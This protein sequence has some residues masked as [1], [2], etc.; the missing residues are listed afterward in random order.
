VVAA[1]KDDDG[2]GAPSCIL[3]IINI[4]QLPK[5]SSSYYFSIK[6]VYGSVKMLTI[7]FSKESDT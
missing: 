3:I 2:G 1:W 7:P 4:F 6:V 5:L